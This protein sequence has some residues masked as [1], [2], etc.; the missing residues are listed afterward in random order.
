MA[1][2]APPGHR[3]L[4]VDA[5]PLIADGENLNSRLWALIKR[6][7]ERGDELHTTGWRHHLRFD[8]GGLIALIQ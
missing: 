3:S 7:L 1:L 5:G 8:Q 2:L 4:I 6:A